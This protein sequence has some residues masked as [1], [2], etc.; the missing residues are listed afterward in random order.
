MGLGVGAWEVSSAWAKGAG[1]G[2]LGTGG[3]GGG[4]GG[5]G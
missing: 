4:G 5:G 2:R 3:A 1:V